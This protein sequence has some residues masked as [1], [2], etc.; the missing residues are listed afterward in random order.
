MT[1]AGV[2]AA[3]FLLACAAPA[4][5]EYEER[6]AAA[7]PA[8]RHAVHDARLRVIMG[9]LGRLSVERLPQEMDTRELRSSR[10]ARVS[11]SSAALARAAER[12]PDVLADV[13]LPD[14]AREEFL[15]LAAV[16]REQS[17]DLS[18]RAPQLSLE[19]MN[20][21]L[22]AIQTTCESCHQRFRVLPVVSDR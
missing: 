19:A 5:R 15:A 4:Q 22:D 16:L 10:V 1:R 18:R 13:E 3:A 21:Q 9:Q 17:A 7:A 11:E 2:A 14:P 20:A 12:I 8:A 6:A